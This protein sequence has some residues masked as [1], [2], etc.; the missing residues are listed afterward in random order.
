[1]SV[2]IAGVGEGDG[3][4]GGRAIGLDGAVPGTSANLAG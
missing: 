4:D 3:D 2:S 1:M